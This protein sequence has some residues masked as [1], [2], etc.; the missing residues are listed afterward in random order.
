MYKTPEERI[1]QLEML[2][3]KQAFQIRLLH[4]LVRD[5]AQYATYHDVLAS[6]MS[7]HTYRRLQNLT[8]HYEMRLLNGESVTLG[9]FL[10]EFKRILGEDTT[11]PYVTDITN[12][13]PR[14]LAGSGNSFGFSPALYE[15][16]YLK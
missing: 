5:Q 7:E 15:A 3:E 6:N 2:V 11:M 14:W 9:N 8:R 1:L 16:F 13:V 12:L 4:D 10:H